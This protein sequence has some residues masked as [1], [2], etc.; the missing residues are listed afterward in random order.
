MRIMRTTVLRHYWRDN[1]IREL[2][3]RCCRIM[4]T[5]LVAI[6]C[7]G[8]SCPAAGIPPPWGAA[9]VSRDGVPTIPG[10]G[11]LAKAMGP[12]GMGPL[13]TRVGSPRGGSHGETGG[14]YGGS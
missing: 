2:L 1:A 7:G 5:K 13:G 4:R 12:L 8:G 10:Q 11:L 9:R 3:R 14:A 6:R